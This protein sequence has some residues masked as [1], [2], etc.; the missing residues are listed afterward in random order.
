MKYF[1]TVRLAWEKV[2]TGK[3]DYMLLFSTAFLTFI[4]LIFLPVVIVPGND[5][6]FQLNI[7]PISD[8]MVLFLLSCI[9][10]VAIVFNIYIFNQKKHAEKQVGN[11]A[12]TILS[13]L[14]SAFFGTITCIACAATIGGLLGLSTVAFVLKYRIIFAII[15][16]F[17]LLASVYFTAQ[18]VIH[19]CK[20]C[21]I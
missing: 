21:A 19:T 16:I 18:R 10:G 7:M 14:S 8:F 9:S 12:V 3:K 5:I 6:F 20:R 4:I 15:S 13:M 2:L 1:Q 17:F 11:T